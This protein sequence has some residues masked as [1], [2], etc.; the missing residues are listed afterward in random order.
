M[1]RRTL[2]LVA[3]SVWL[4]AGLWPPQSRADTDDSF[5]VRNVLD[6]VTLCSVPKDDPLHTAAANFLPRLR[7]RRIPLLQGYDHRGGTRIKN[8]SSAC[9]ILSLRGMRRFRL[10]RVG[11][12]PSPVQQR[13]GGGDLV[14]VRDREM[15]LPSLIRRAHEYETSIKFTSSC[16]SGDRFDRL[17]GDDSS[18]QRMMSGTG[19][20]AAGGAVI[21]AMAGNAG[22]GAGI[23]AATGLLGGYLY[24]QHK[25][26][27]KRPTSRD[28]S[29]KKARSSP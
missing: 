27:E 7:G 23:G 16:I 18:Q 4:V 26:G 21:G 3:A 17:L 28:T 24:D 1:T 19:M 6:I 9:P 11:S 14:Q 25:Q 8:R 20:G 10:R 13:A 22:L 5:L 29:R 15:A 12:G 2:T